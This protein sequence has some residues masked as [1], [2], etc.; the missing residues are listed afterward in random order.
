M[1]KKTQTNQV[2]EVEVEAA[3]GN[4]P[5]EKPFVPTVGV[6]EL[7]PDGTK[8]HLGLALQEAAN[9]A[10]LSIAEYMNK[11]KA[12]A[13]AEKSGVAVSLL[14]DGRLACI[15]PALADR[16]AQNSGAVRNK[17]IGLLAVAY[18]VQPGDKHAFSSK[19]GVAK[20]DGGL[21]IRCQ[22]HNL[23]DAGVAEHVQ[24]GLTA[25]CAGERLHRAGAG[26]ATSKASGVP[27]TIEA[28][29]AFDSAGELVGK[30]IES[31]AGL[32]DAQKAK[33]ATFA[34]KRVF[35]RFISEVESVKDGASALPE[36]LTK[37]LADRDALLPLLAAS[38]EAIGNLESIKAMLSTA[39]AEALKVALQGALDAAQTET[40]TAAAALNS[41]RDSYIATYGNNFGSMQAKLAKLE[42]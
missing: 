26:V 11:C 15:S 14:D 36:L 34:N 13:E 38:D 39:T 12:E 29:D 24:T 33:L 41:A 18:S 42:S 31:L 40:E 23:A 28:F 5:A 30:A 6:P 16:L 7:L 27:E 4:P 35:S 1:S 8:N 19:V 22:G 21:A 9:K 37:Q 20:V 10:G 17:V 32:D 2:P 3:I 25:F